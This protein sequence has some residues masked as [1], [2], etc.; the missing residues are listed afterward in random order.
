MCPDV[1][2]AAFIVALNR[3]HTLHISV[4]HSPSWSHDTRWTEWVHTD[5]ES[6]DVDGTPNHFGRG[7]PLG[8][9]VWQAL[10]GRVC[11]PGVPLPPLMA[12]GNCC[13]TTGCSAR[14]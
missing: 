10:C 4:A 11:A 8:L 7:E 2:R 12:S 13:V 5:G 3:M 14:T 1:P 9:G 6:E